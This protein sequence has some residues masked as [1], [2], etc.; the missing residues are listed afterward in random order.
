[1]DPT[2]PVFPQGPTISGNGLDYL[3]PFV[4]ECRPILAKQGMDAVQ[5]HLANAGLGIVPSIAATRGLLGWDNTT[6]AQ[7][8]DIVCASPARNP[9]AE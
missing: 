2:P 7:A 9:L 5:Q 3:I 6:L 4:E 8:R 1:M